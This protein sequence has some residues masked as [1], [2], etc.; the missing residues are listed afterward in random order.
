M[1]V[2]NGCPL[3]AGISHQQALGLLQQAGDT[4]ELVV[5]RDGPLSASS[6]RVP[7]HLTGTVRTS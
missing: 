6:P 2:I 3:E 1:L 4:V 5:A 7:T